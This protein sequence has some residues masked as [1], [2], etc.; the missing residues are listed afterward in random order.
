MCLRSDTQCMCRV[1]TDAEAIATTSYKEILIWRLVL[2]RE[3]DREDSR[4][5]V[6][7]EHVVV[8][9]NR[10]SSTVDR[11]RKGLV[12]FEV[13]SELLGIES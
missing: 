1:I 7:R 13:R 11:V 10:Y 12:L 4:A 3:P 2:M 9:M 8:E 5:Q 6:E